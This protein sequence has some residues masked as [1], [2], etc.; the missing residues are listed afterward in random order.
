MASDPATGALFDGL[1]LTSP[2]YIGINK[3]INYLD[4]RSALPREHKRL[5]E[6]DNYKN[7]D[8]YLAKWQQA[9]RALEHD[10]DAQLP[11]LP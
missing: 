5:A 1:A 11:A 10:A 6:V 2:R 4:A 7:G 8:E 3:V 9:L